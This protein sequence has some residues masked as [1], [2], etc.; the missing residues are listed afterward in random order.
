MKSSIL[1]RPGRLF[2]LL[3]IAIIATM[4]GS[5]AFTQQQPATRTTPPQTRPNQQQMMQVVAIV[6]GQQI[7]RQQ[8]AQQCLRRFGDQVIESVINKQLILN[9]LRRR[10]IQITVADVNREIKRQAAKLNFSTEHY[11]N[12]I[13]EKR[14]ISVDRIKNDIFWVELALKTL[15]K[16]QIN[17][18]YEEINKRFET[19]FGEKVLIRIIALKSRD[20]AI[21][22]QQHLMQSPQDFSQMAIKHSVDSNSAA[23]GGQLPPIRKHTGDPKLEQAAFALKPGQIS[24]VVQLGDP[25]LDQERQYFIMKCEQR[26][27]AAKLNAQSKALNET[28]ITDEIRNNKL[29]VAATNLFKKL[30]ESVKIVNVYNDP[31]LSKK[32]P[33]VAATV[34]NQQIT[35]R[36]LSEECIVRYGPEVL[37]GIID[38][39][40]LRQALQKA[41]LQVTDADTQAEIARAAKS[42]GF[43]KNGKADIEKWLQVFTRGDRSKIPFYV[44][45]IVWPTVALKKLVASTIKITPQDEQKEFVSQFGERVE[46]L[47][48][49]IS[50]AKRA[51]KVWDMARKNPTEEFF[52]NLSGQYSDDPDLRANRGMMDPVPRYKKFPE[53]VTQEIFKLKRGQMTGLC[54]VGNFW[55]IFYCRGRTKPLVKNFD[56]V[57]D[58]LRRDLKEEKYRIAMNKY[59]GRLRSSAQIDNFIVGTSQAGRQ[60]I[61]NARQQHPTQPRR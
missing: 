56:D 34:D 25:Q 54:Q 39:T 41:G 47:A 20:K 38:R 15:A 55:A 1:K 31:V 59:F 18:T 51:N 49:V 22:I 44:E 57:K 21:Q 33:G 61:Q 19:E 11:L 4:T 60:A 10:N 37:N 36:Y 45:D 35:L 9:E 26:Y 6:N 40:L 2:N 13:R 17:V 43:E 58:I 48:I 3:A 12:V 16:D 8:L 5:T 30:Q 7:T 14:N 28:R 53:N 32:M 23:Q 52:G 50:N 29:R 46:V 24:Q 27:P 42:Y